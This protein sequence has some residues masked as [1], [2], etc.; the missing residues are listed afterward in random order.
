MTSSNHSPL[1]P[2]SLDTHDTLHL[3][4]LAQRGSPSSLDVLFDRVRPRLLGFV[5]KRL[6]GWLRKLEQSS[7]LVQD[8]LAIAHQR[9]ASFE[10]QGSG[11]FLNWLARITYNRARDRR[12]FYR[13]KRRRIVKLEASGP[14]DLDAVATEAV[15][16][17]DV[18][19]CEE[20]IRALRSSVRELPVPLQELIRLRYEHG[21]P[22]ARIAERLGSSE[23]SVRRRHAEALL[24]LG[25]ALDGDERRGADGAGS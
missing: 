21:L 16:P 10:P 20:E 14:F 18:L 24:I 1:V 9:L 8:V 5:R 3:V 6:D 7:D 22:F 12:R 17:P 23:S 13:S 11:S 2:A 15:A 19:A 25:R 4:Q